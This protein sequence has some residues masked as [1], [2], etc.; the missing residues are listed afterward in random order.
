MKIAVT[1]IDEISTSA[2]TE[3]G[4]HVAFTLRD[5]LGNFMTLG[6]P[7]EEVPNLID[8][9]A[10]AL[11]EKERIVRPDGDGSGRLAITWWNLIRNDR[12]GEFV[13]SLT[14]GAGGSLDFVL[15]EHMAASLKDT[16]RY[17]TEGFR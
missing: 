15:T 12:A 1:M 4:R 11:S 8:H 5:S 14:F 13:L 3:D 2:V 17:Y 10:C 16:L 9:A 7:S 6:L